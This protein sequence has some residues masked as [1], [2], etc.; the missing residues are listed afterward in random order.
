[1]STIIKQGDQVFFQ[2]EGQMITIIKGKFITDQGEKVDGRK[3]RGLLRNKN[4][5]EKRAEVAHLKSIF[6]RFFGGEYEFN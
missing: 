1:M 2:F 6:N 4:N 5:I 3:V